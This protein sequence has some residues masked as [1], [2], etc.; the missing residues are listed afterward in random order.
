MPL[1]LARLAPRT[2]AAREESNAAPKLRTAVLGAGM[3]GIDLAR[4]LIGSASL[5]TPL[6]AGREGSSGLRQA[7][8]MGC[9][10]STSGIRAV[11]DAHVDIVFDASSAEAHPAHWAELA[12]ADVML[13]DLTP[14]SGGTMVA[15]T[16][17]GF[18][19]ET[20][21]HL[22]L[23]SC[24][25]Q[26]VLP[27]LNVVAKHSTVNYVEVVTTVAS[28]SIGPATRNN[29]DEYVAT[30][31]YAVRRLT[32]AATTKVLATISP[33]LPAPAFRAQITALAD[34]INR[35]A[36]IAGVESVASA[37]RA[38]APGYEVT[39]LGVSGD[40]ITATVTVAARGGCLPAFAGNVEIINA[41][42]VTLAEG[43]ANSRRA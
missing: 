39:A 36:L 18:R 14:S 19:V 24:G 41:A 1:D 12:S 33:A 40:R 26:A 29:L 17:N 5:D 32:D 22:S 43:Y 23:V 15:P 7:A 10:I 25:G 8:R 35:D 6:V 38:F 13:I 20:H 11:L 42:A 16:V 37:V 21:R 4:R 3:L 28:A 31:G 9:V 2:T 34:G 27:V 30:T